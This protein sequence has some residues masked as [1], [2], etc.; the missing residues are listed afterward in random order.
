MLNKN[1]GQKSIFLIGANKNNFFDLTVLSFKKIISSECVVLSKN[2]NKNFISELKNVC[3]VIVYEE[4]ICLNNK[5]K[6]LWNKILSLFQ[7]YKK[8]SHLKLYDPLFLNDGIEEY[9]F[10]KTNKIIAG[11]FSGII[12]IIELLN[13]LE[14][15]I[16]DRRINSSVEF[17]NIN[18]KTDFI[19][20]KIILQEKVIIKISTSKLLLQLLD[21]NKIISENYKTN[22]ILPIKHEEFY[23]KKLKG[24]NSQKEV[25][26]TPTENIFILIEKNEKI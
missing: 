20:K 16:T 6:K 12:E 23:S 3:S 26:F 17:I 10:F 1:I 14:I 8:I 4:D 18:K 7:K 21:S 24:Y 19:K 2:F 22:I 25:I 11:I 15:P 13:N 9:E 5:K